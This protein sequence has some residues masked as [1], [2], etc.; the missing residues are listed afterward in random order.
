MR[1][2]SAPVANNPEF[3]DLAN[4]I[5]QAAA[6]APGDV[7]AESALALPAPGEAGRTC[8]DL[9]TDVVNKIRENMQ[10]VRVD[11]LRGK[12]GNYVHF[13][14]KIGVL[15]QVEG[16]ASAELLA[17]CACTSRP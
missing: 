6:E 13:N 2:E 9:V 7:T 3:R 17:D 1:C 10:V 12:L 16:D 15:L 4:K 5:A 8:R 11:R 14:G